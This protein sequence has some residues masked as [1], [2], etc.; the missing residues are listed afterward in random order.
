MFGILIFILLEFLCPGLLHELLSAEGLLGLFFLGLEEGLLH[1]LGHLFVFEDWVL[2]ALLHGIL[3]EGVHVLGLFEGVLHCVSIGFNFSDFFPMYNE[4]SFPYPF[5]KV[6]K[7]RILE[8][9]IRII[10]HDR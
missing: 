3:V 1:G 6:Q 9:G 7:L 4:L 10:Q 8:P 2:E 5:Q